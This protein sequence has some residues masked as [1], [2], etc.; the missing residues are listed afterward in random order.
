MRSYPLNSP[1]PLD[2]REN[3]WKDFHNPNNYS[4][5]K[6][7]DKKQDFEFEKRSLKKSLGHKSTSKYEPCRECI[8]DLRE[9]KYCTSSQ[10]KNYD[11]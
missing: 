6:E 8:K 5:K 10:Y 2:V 4:L 9:C 1:R 3:V 11:I 7:H